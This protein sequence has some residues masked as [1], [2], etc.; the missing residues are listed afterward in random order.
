MWYNK[1]PIVII[2]LSFFVGIYFY[3]KMPDKI[4]SH[5]NIRSEV[6]G[7]LPKVWGLFL[8]PLVSLGIYGLFIALPRID[9]LKKNIEAFKKYYFGFILIMIV[10]LFY[11][12]IL[13]IVANLG[14]GFDMGVLLIPGLSLLFLYIGIMLEN[15][16]RNWFIG[17][18]TPWTLQS[19]KVWEKTHK[20][21]S[22][23][24]KVSS[25][26]ILIGIFLSKYVFWI[27]IGS[28]T[29]RAFL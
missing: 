6:D 27:V 13:T 23:L 29:I 12:Y 5:W 8:M 28:A 15:S 25:V 2:L 21:G 11:I 7:Y 22:I 20:L 10:F 4:A 9:P 17:I 18:R 1:T 16:K 3:P 19:D 24:F 26:L 14:Y